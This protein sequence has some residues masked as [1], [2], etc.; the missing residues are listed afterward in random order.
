MKSDRHAG[1]GSVATF[2]QEEYKIHYNGAPAT[3]WMQKA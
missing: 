3:A 2:K 1:K